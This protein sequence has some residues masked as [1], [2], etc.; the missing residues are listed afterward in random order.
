[1][2]PSGLVDSVVDVL[3][4]GR[5]G[6]ADFQGCGQGVGGDQRPEESVVDLGVEDRHALPLGGQVVGVGLRPSFDEA[7]AA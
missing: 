7:L 2:T 4:D 3:V 6:A 5:Q 1:L